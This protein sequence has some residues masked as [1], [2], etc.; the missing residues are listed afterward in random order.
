M[1]K[2]PASSDQGSL[3]TLISQLVRNAL[4]AA[5]PAASP[6]ATVDALSQPQSEPPRHG[7]LDQVVSLASVVSLPKSTLCIE[8]LPRAV[9]TPAAADWL[10]QHGVSVARGSVAK[11]D[12]GASSSPLSV[13]SS[14]AS[15]VELPR[16]ILDVDRPDRA[17]AY[18]KQLLHRG[19]TVHPTD[20]QHITATWQPHTLE[21]GIVV[22]SFSPMMVDLF[23][24]QG[25]VSAVEVGSVDRVRRIAQTM[26]PKIWVIDA[27]RLSF[28]SL[29]TVAAE[30][31][32]TVTTARLPET[33]LPS[34]HGGAR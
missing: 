29:V 16:W 23:A 27:E 5:S 9:V 4:H 25:M 26:Q 19:V 1:S 2:H 7:V 32:R 8:I 28:S 3:E 14:V 33:S 6:A 31:L 22:T 20:L 30:C 17:A 21:R 12:E 18:A 11:V 24:R 13:A 34:F 15:S 10:R